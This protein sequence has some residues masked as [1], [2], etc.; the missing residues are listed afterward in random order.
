MCLS[1]VLE[2]QKM[3]CQGLF[4][5]MRSVRYNPNRKINWINYNETFC[6]DALSF[7][8]FNSTE[9]ISLNQLE[10]IN[11]V[12]YTNNNFTINHLCTSY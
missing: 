12:F 1:N 3:E 11:K 9:K 7:H 6:M 8:W 10:S 5:L 2:N 4:D